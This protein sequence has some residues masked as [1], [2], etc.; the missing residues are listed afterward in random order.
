VATV[1]ATEYN[2]K[3]VVQVVAYSVA[4]LIS[5][6]RITEN[7]HWVTDVVTGAAIGYLSGKLVVKKIHWFQKINSSEK[8]R[9]SVSFSVNYNF[10]YIEPCLI[11]KFR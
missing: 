4:S 10:G 8:R 11:Y 2:D 3:P 9:N 7:K 5:I 6:S 1:F